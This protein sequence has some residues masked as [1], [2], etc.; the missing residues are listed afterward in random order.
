LFPGAL[1]PG[2][3]HERLILVSNPD[4]AS[5]AE[6][7]SFPVVF[8]TPWYGLLNSPRTAP[9]EAVLVHAAA[10]GVGMA[11]VQG[12]RPLGAEV[13]ATASP[14]KWDALRAL[15]VPDGRIADSRTL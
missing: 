7:A 15:G 5:F 14:G 6:A 8:L 3:R 9:G 4:G 1:C 11:A 2:A 10:G 13:Y 12:A